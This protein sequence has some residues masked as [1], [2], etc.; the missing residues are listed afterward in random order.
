[1]E[2]SRQLLKKAVELDSAQYFS[3][4]EVLCVQGEIEEAIDNIELALEHGYRSLYG[5][6]ANPDLAALRYD[7][8]LKNLLDKYFRP[9]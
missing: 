9:D 3:F 8:R 7:I 1:M 2:L 5:L 6:T 4:A